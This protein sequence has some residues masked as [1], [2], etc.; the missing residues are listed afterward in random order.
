MCMYIMWKL[1]F[2]A[3]LDSEQKETLVK[4]TCKPQ[5]HDNHFGCLGSA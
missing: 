4:V 3:P 5:G 2:P 1:L